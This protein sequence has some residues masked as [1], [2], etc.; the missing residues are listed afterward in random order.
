MASGC[1]GKCGTKT[2]PSANV[3]KNSPTGMADPSRAIYGFVIYLTS[4]VLLGQ[5]FVQTLQAVSSV[6]R[7]ACAFT[8]GLIACAQHMDT[9]TRYCPT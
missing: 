1:E 9:Q 6:C 4:Y 3:K 7:S 8:L 2:R 5:H